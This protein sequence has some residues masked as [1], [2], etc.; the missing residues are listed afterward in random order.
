MLCTSCPNFQ[1]LDAYTSS[2]GQI[3]DYK[4]ELLVVDG[5][6]LRQLVNRACEIMILTR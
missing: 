4:T 2:L 3:K 6:F 1:V 5:S